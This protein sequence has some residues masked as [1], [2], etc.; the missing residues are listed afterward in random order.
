VLASIRKVQKL[1]VSKSLAQLKSSQQFPQTTIA[2]QHIILVP[3][4]RNLRNQKKLVN[5]SQN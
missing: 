3:V 5:L 1:G 2:H 4:M